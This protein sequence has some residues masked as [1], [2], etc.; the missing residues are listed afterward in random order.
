MAADPIWRSIYR[1]YRGHS[2]LLSSY[3]HKVFKGF[4]K[5]QPTSYILVNSYR[6]Q[7]TWWLVRCE[8]TK[9][10]RIKIM[11]KILTW[12]T[13]ASGHSLDVLGLPFPRPSFLPRWRHAR[14]DL[15]SRDRRCTVEILHLWRGGASSALWGHHGSWLQRHWTRLLLLLLGL[16]LLILVWTGRLGRRSVHV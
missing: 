15:H 2:N 14:A 6:W 4:L 5:D 16:L 8:N 12:L 11:K 7:M 10:V 3:L 13:K 9:P 1:F